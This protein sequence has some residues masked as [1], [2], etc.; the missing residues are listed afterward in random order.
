MS[1]ATTRGHLTRAVLEGVA[2]QV[3]E[4]LE[5]M[6]QVMGSIDRL[7]LFG[8]GAKSWL[9][10]AILG[11]V[12]GCPVCWTPSS[13]TASLGAAML[14]AVGCDEF[15]NLNEARDAMVKMQQQRPPDAKNV[16]LYDAAYAAYRAIE[17]KLLGNS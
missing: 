10:R 12:A 17:C 11:D 4:N 8:G 9:W 1:L 5:V 2:F 6:R 15:P 3:R 13:E 16:A 7:I 14:A